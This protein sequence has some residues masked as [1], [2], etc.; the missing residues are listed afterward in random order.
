MLAAETGHAAHVLKTALY[1][2]ACAPCEAP[3]PERLGVPC[4]A[5]SGM[6]F[7]PNSFSEWGSYLALKETQK[8]RLAFDLVL[9]LC[10]PGGL[11]GEGRV[12][13]L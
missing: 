3:T 9:P 10:S 13:D 2:T 1:S 4:T 11:W 6:C 8:C 12:G 7:S 5:P